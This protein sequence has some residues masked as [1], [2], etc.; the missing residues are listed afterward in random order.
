MVQVGESPLGRGFVVGNPNSIGE[1]VI[2]LREGRRRI[3]P[4]LGVASG[5]P[6]CGIALI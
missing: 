6:A 3:Q 2:V 5:G 4:G 1:L